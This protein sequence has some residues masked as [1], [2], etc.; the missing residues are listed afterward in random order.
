MSRKEAGWAAMEF[1][2]MPIEIRGMLRENFA[3]FDGSIHGPIMT[4]CGNHQTVSTTPES[5]MD[6]SRVS[7]GIRCAFAVAAMT[8]SNGSP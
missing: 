6:R 3:E 4:E 8:R 2:E 1:W 7:N 5:L